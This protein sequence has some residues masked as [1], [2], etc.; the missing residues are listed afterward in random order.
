MDPRSFESP[1]KH[2]RELSR[3]IEHFGGVGGEREK[4]I[5]IVQKL[6]VGKSFTNLQ[7]MSAIR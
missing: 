2:L 7:E 6:V 5:V 1:K 3:T 4:T